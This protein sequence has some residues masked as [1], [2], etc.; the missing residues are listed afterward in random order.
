METRSKK[1]RRLCNRPFPLDDLLILGIMEQYIHEYLVIMPS[2]CKYIQQLINRFPYHRAAVVDDLSRI[3]LSSRENIRGL[4][5]TSIPSRSFYRLTNLCL[6]Y[7]DMNKQL[8]CFLSELRFLKLNHAFF[9][10]PNP[11]L[12]SKIPKNLNTLH[13]TQVPYS[14]ALI[15]DLRDFKTLQNFEYSEFRANLDMLPDSIRSIDCSICSETTFTRI[16]KDAK[17]LCIRGIDQKQANALPKMFPNLNYVMLGKSTIHDLAFFNNW[18][19]LRSA[20]VASVYS[21]SA[22]RMPRFRFSSI[23]DAF[24]AWFP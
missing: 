16:Y 11:I 4:E 8:P 23:D 14:K 2:V 20:L 24:W 9:Y 5:T 15:L 6:N 10:G 13:V 22:S 3:P 1:R 19:H 7:V 21:M 17:T 18:F 12:F